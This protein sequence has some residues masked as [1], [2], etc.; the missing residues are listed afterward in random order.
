MI[1][2]TCHGQG[3]W[4]ERHPGV[5]LGEHVGTLTRWVPCPDCIGGVASCC[6]AAGSA[7]QLALPLDAA[8]GSAQPEPPAREDEDAG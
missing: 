8:A 4:H 5:R 1:C 2:E 6:D 7:E 3:G